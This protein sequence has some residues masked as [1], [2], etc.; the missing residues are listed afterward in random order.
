MTGINNSWAGNFSF[1][2]DELS[3]RKTLTRPNGV[4]TSYDYNSL[5]NL[6]SVLHKLGAT[7][8][9]GASYTNDNAGNRIGKTNHINN[10]VEEYAYDAIYQLTQVKRDGAVVESYNYDPVGNRLNS[11]GVPSYTHNVS[12]Q[13][14]A[15]STLAFTYDNNGNT[16]T[17]TDENGVTTYNW[18]YENRLTNVVL[19]GEAGSVSFKYD[20]FGRRIQK[21]SASGVTNYAY[22]GANAVG[23]YDSAGTLVARYTQDSGVDEPLALQ[24][25]TTMGYYHADGLGSI[26]SLTDG[27]GSALAAYTYDAFGKPLVGGGDVPN[28][29]RYTAREWD[30]E[31]GLYYYRARYYDPRVG[32]F[33]SEDPLGIGAGTNG[34]VY[35]DNNSI[36]RYDPSGLTTVTTS[37][38]VI[39]VSATV[40]IYGPYASQG[41]AKYWQNI[42]NGVWNGHGFNYYYGKCKVVFDFKVNA[43]P[44]N[45]YWFTASAAD[46]RVYVEPYV[47]RFRSHQWRGGGRGAWWQGEDRAV[48][49]EMGHVLGLRDQYQDYWHGYKVPRGWGDSSYPYEDHELD[50]MGDSEEGVPTQEEINAIVG[51]KADSECGGCKK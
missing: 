45:N 5:S 29:Y 10:T 47:P 32:R 37:Q 18:D 19:P 49:H 36:T 4:V 38:G 41:L 17:K 14:T 27:T 31:T 9:D 42:M 7:T 28:P 43:E 44:A 30:S 2:Y 16:Q 23:E 48:A 21:S 8:I 3:R 20:P 40:T 25:G 46:A 13:L 39:T 26:T 24:H 15:T 35:A 1:T 22:D 12:N 51:G 11:L 34:Y 33:I 6:L 50:I